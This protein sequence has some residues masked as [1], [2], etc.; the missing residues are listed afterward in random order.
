MSLK[1][2][3]EYIASITPV[4]ATKPNTTQTLNK[5]TLFQ[6]NRKKGFEG[7]SGVRG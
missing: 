6:N 3:R 7:I 4:R 2:S 1:I 5:S